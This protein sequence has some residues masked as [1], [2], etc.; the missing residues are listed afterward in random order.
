MGILGKAA[1]SAAN[2]VIVQP[3]KKKYV[4]PAQEKM[5]NARDLAKR[6][7]LLKAGKCP[8]NPSSSKHQYQGRSG[9]LRCRH[10]EEPWKP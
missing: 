7:A 2:K 10:C 6:R 3:V 5:G 1:K 9:D 8:D 4:A